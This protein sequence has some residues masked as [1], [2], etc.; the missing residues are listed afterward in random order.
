[1]YIASKDFVHIVVLL[2]IEEENIR[3]TFCVTEVK[4][5]HKSRTLHNVPNCNEYKEL[6]KIFKISVA[7]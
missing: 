1:M 6:F 7:T 4:R 5:M 2:G 3:K